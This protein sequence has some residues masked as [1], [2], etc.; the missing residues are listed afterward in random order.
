MV[1]RFLRDLGLGFRVGLWL[2]G[3]SAIFE[4]CDCSGSRGNTA[5]VRAGFRGHSMLMN[6]EIS[7][8]SCSLGIDALGAISLYI[9]GCVFAWLRGGAILADFAVDVTIQHASSRHTW[10]FL[11]A[12]TVRTVRLRGVR[13]SRQVFGTVYIFS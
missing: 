3:F 1:T 13:V 9:H 7:T 6:T 5:V 2:Q 12:R 10:M 11:K 8:S 4:N